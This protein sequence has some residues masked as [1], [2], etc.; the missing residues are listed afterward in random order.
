MEVTASM[1]DES[2]DSDKVER[3][4]R[5]EDICATGKVEDD[6]GVERGWLHL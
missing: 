6:G 5:D 2:E 3:Q 4:G 1:R